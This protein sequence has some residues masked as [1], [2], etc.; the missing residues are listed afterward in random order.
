MYV[1]TILHIRMMH[2]PLSQ[3]SN[4]LHAKVHPFHVL[5]DA[6]FSSCSS[7]SPFLTF[8]YVYVCRIL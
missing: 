6:A 5:G 3:G 1:H 2:M 4:M 8:P 7:S